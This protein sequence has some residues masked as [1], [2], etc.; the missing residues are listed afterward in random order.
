MP[1]RLFNLSLITLVLLCAAGLRFRALSLDARFHPDEALF[2]TFA[3]NAAVHGDWMLHGPLDKSPLSIYAAALSMHFVGAFITE[4]GVID[5]PVRQGEFAARLPN[6]LAGVLTI[7]VAY[8]LAKRVTPRDPTV[9]LIAALLM[10]VSPMAVGISASAFTDTFMLLFGVGSALAAASGHTGWSGMLL[11]LSIASK[12][13][14]IFFLPLTMGI[15]WRSLRSGRSKK[16]FGFASAFGGGLALLLLWD[17]MRGETSIFA[18]A[19]VNNNPGRLLT[20]PEEWWP[21]LRQWAQHAWTMFGG[22]GATVA[23][24][25]IAIYACFVKDFEPQSTHRTRRGVQSKILALFASWR[26][27]TLQAILGVFA[28]AYFALH[29]IGALNLYDRYLL[30]LVPLIALLVASGMVRLM[31]RKQAFALPVI[32]LIL[33]VVVLGVGAAGRVNHAN[34]DDAQGILELAAYLNA[35]P[36]GT[37]LYDHWLGWQMGY[38]L[39]AWTDK[40]RVYYPDPETQAQDALCNPDPAPR[41]LIAPDGANVLP[42]LTAFRD[43]DFDVQ[44]VYGLRGFRA[45]KIIPP[46]AFQGG[47]DAESSWQAPA[48]CADLPVSRSG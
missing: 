6:V 31:Y 30:P 19:S 28:L 8:A 1:R 5:V 33:T 39:G 15:S 16:V 47:G 9:W 35:K 37:I 38:Y 32:A 40:R 29:W 22:A 25:M 10:A 14:G 36:L 27:N 24:I 48:G 12:Q 2:S 13:Q 34:E 17:W 23:L 42:W 20:S 45:Y 4:D 43:N 18:L 11:A 7:A 41:Y 21:R 26:S 3:R 46:W 44:G